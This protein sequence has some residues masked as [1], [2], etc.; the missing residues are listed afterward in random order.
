MT[1]DEPSSSCLHHEVWS[2]SGEVLVYVYHYTRD[3][4][5]KLIHNNHE[6]IKIIRSSISAVSVR[7][8]P[9]C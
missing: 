6:W 4:I 1:S 2:I 7:E 8:R 9:G 5:K 3:Q